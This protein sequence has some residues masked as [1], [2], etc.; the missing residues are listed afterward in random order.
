MNTE[1]KKFSMEI[2]NETL[3][4]L[5]CVLK[6][7]HKENK[8]YIDT[9]VYKK[10]KEDYNK[11]ETHADRKK[12]IKLLISNDKYLNLA[13]CKYDN[14]YTN[15]NSLL[16]LFIKII[17]HFEQLLKIKTPA[18]V[19]KS[20]AIINDPKNKKVLSDIYLKNFLFHYLNIITYVKLLLLKKNHK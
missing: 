1:V 2:F 9:E 8:E 14:C 15:V 18:D 4:I 20:I 19:V 11:M 10:Y 13:K 7:C 17:P 12:I 5:D 3:N 16:L 6:K